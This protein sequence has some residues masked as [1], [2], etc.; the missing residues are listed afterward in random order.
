MTGELLIDTLRWM[1]ELPRF[2]DP[3]KMAVVID[4][5]PCHLTV[6]VA[7]AAAQLG[8]DLCPVPPGSTGKCQPM[9]VSVFGVLKRKQIKLHDGAMRE[10]PGRAWTEADAVRT[11]IEAW[12]EIDA[13]VVQSAWQRARGEADGV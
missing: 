13:N 1:R 7:M 6:D 12:G 11:M 4:Q 3:A 2:A 9:D 8:V 5:A 10:C